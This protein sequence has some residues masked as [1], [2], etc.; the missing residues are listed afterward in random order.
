MDDDGDA[1]LNPALGNQEALVSG[2]LRGR[3]PSSGWVPG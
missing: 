3:L 1:G 2:A